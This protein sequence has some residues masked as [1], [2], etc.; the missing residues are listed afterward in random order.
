MADLTPRAGQIVAAAREL[1][2]AGG[3]EA[4]T[5]RA[6]AARLGIRAPSLYKHFPDKSAVEAQLI[7]LALT[8]LAETLERAEGGGGAGETSER[9]EGDAGL[10]ETGKRAEG[11]GGSGGVGERVEGGL[12][13]LGRAYRAYA[14]AHPHL[15]R[16]MSAGPLPRGLLP[17]GVEERAALPLVRLV[18]GEAAARA[19]W[20]LAHGLVMLELDGR[21]P[22]GADID[23][24]WTA[25]LS[26]FTPPPAT[27]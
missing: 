14:L 2:E 15:Y 23:A 10:T 5:M 27:L 21:F 6:L 7:T 3:V 24:A 26:A 18:R 25:G 4:L 19:V 8:E 17:A 9:A 11:D 12:Q 16:L 1:V 20:G 13:G 22:P